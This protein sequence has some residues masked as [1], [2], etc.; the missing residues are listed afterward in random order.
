MNAKQL[1]LRAREIL[2]KEG[3]VKGAL[4]NRNGYCALG[5]LSEANKANSCFYVYQKAH[6]A[7]RAQMGNIAEF[8][9]RKTTTKEDV[10]AKFCDAAR[11]LEE[12]PPA[13]G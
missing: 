10:L 8:N 9:D 13:A 1:L 4:Y 6:E 2:I 3:W 5:A 11:S 12:S 7:L